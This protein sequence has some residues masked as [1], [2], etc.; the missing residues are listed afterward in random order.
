MPL[1]CNKFFPRAG[2][3][4]LAALLLVGC[5]SSDKKEDEH[6][7]VRLELSAAE[8][9]N[10]DVNGRPSPV[11]VRLYRLLRTEA[12][13]GAD[14]FALAERDS[15]V[16]GR[17]L[18][19]RESLMIAPGESAVREYVVEDDVVALGVT[20]AYRDL[21]SSIWR[22]VIVLREGDDSGSGMPSFLRWSKPSANFSVHLGVQRVELVAPAAR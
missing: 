9:L 13:E 17:D 2:L 6:L 4:V 15:E 14:Y 20:V 21:E 1:S 19:Q 7:A 18:S 11:Q 16:L 10:P 3:A 22:Q 5:S 8:R 12:F